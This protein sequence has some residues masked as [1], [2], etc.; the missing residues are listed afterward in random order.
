MKKKK[1][2][3]ETQISGKWERTQAS[4]AGG[5]LLWN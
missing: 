3:I 2:A 1:I 4:A 5:R